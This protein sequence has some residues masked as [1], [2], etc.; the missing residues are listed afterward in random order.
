MQNNNI[1]FFETFGLITGTGDLKTALSHLIQL[2]AEAANADAASIYVVD[3][4]EKVLKP[5]ITYGLP[6]AYVEAC[7][8]I[9][10]GDQCCGRAVQHRKPW[11]VSDMLSDPLFA[12][13]R[14]AA[15]VSP[16]RAAFSVPIID[17]DDL[18]V[19]SLACHYFEPYTPNSKDIARNKT[20]ATMIAHTISSY[21]HSLSNPATLGESAISG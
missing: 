4:N 15:L 12:T 1:K 5:L 6:Q 11:V 16:I 13:A 9:Q 17:Q 18:C 3:S 14:A 19:G 10:I 20:W 2:A 7:G 21:R 8:N